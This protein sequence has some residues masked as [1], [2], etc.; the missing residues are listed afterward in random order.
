MCVQL[1]YVRVKIIEIWTKIHFSKKTET[2]FFKGSVHCTGG[3]FVDCE[4]SL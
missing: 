2:Q 1:G 3:F 4:V